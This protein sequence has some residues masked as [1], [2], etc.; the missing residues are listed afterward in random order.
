MK[1]VKKEFP[2]RRGDR[3]NRFCGSECMRQ[4]RAIKSKYCVWCL[5]EYSPND[6]QQKF[7][8]RSCGAKMNNALYPKRTKQGGKKKKPNK[9]GKYIKYTEVFC[10][11]CGSQ[12]TK[13][14]DN[15]S[16]Y[17]NSKCRAD[18]MFNEW[19]NGA[20]LDT[21]QWNA[22]P[23]SI[24]DR[25]LVEADYQCQ[26]VR[27]DTGLRCTE[28]RR[29]SSGRSILEVEHKDGDSTNNMAY[30]IELLCPSC[31]SLTETYRSGNRGKST[32]IWRKEYKRQV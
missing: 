11:W 5:V 15:V 16:E 8:S 14:G 19:K 29:R 17:C 21:Y 31:H 32:R 4:Y 28:S 9:D 26:A 24:K 23:K 12:R 1:T 2:V 18:H 25:L 3:P 6:S 7:C 10:L 22:F 27:S 30:N 13:R 20:A